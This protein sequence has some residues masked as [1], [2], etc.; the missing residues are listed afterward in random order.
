MQEV[1]KNKLSSQVIGLMILRML[2]NK[3]VN[4]YKQPQL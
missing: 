1:E 3:L 4:S 2:M